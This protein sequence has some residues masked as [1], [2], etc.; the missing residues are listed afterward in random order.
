LIRVLVH[1]LQEID[2]SSEAAWVSF[3]NYLV[4]KQIF[5]KPFKDMTQEDT[6]SKALAGEVARLATGAPT[7]DAKS[8]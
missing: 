7:Q 2:M 5:E 8:V 6:L 3:G 1:L 4:L